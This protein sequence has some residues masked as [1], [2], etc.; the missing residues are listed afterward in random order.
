MRAGRFRLT[1]GATRKV[2]SGDVMIRP[3]AALCLGCLLALAP[4]AAGQEASRES[5]A[6][7][8]RQA[9]ARVILEAMVPTS[10]TNYGRDWDALSVRVSSYM[11]WHLAPPDQATDITSSTGIRRNGWV[12]DGTEQI[13]ISAYGFESVDSLTF[14]LS[15][16]IAAIEPADPDADDTVIAALKA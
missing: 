13:G 14:A 11:H 4:V 12:G 2:G 9:M 15:P 10:R 16:R 7:T 5:E 6:P 3:I 1:C 8:A